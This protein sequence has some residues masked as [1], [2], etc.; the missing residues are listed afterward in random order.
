MNSVNVSLLSD[1]DL[2]EIKSTLA[3]FSTQNLEDIVVDGV[4]NTE[5]IVHTGAKQAWDKQPYVNNILYQVKEVFKNN[6]IDVRKYAIKSA[7]VFSCIGGL[8]Y[9][10]RSTFGTDKVLQYKAVTQLQEFAD[11]GYKADLV[12]ITHMHLYPR[13]EQLTI[14]GIVNSICNKLVV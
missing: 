11:C 10:V 7:I 12:I 14:L 2:I 9:N 6:C 8:E 1:S 13:D 3:T 4:I 5:L